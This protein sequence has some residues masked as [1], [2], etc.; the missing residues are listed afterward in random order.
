MYVCQKISVRVTVACVVAPYDV[1]LRINPAHFCAGGSR[2]VNR[3]VVSVFQN[4]AVPDSVR[5][6]VETDNMSRAIDTRNPGKDRVRKVDSVELAD[7]ALEAVKHV[8]RT[9]VSAHN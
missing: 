3:D 7:Q 4:E 9:V 2:N 6:V 5:Q 8:V 1:V